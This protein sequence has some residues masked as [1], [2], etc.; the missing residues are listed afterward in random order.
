MTRST[1]DSSATALYR[2]CPE[3]SAGLKHLYVGG[4]GD[5]Q[6]TIMCTKCF[7]IMDKVPE[8]VIMELLSEI[9][10]DKGFD[11]AECRRRQKLAQ[12]DY[13]KTLKELTTFS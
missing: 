10:A 12:E 9:N 3:C 1:L 8:I 5:W 4:V 7:K 11:I 6:D 13:E 2:K